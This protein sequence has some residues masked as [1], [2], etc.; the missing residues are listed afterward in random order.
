MG[1]GPASREGIGRQ[2]GTD[3]LHHEPDRG[4]RPRDSGRVSRTHL[5][6]GRRTIERVLQRNGLTAPRVHLAP[7]LPPQEYPGP[8]ARASNQLHEV[9]LVGPIYLKGQSHPAGTQPAGSRRRGQHQGPGRA[10]RARV[11]GMSRYHSGDAYVTMADGSARVPKASIA[12]PVSD[13]PH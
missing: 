1:T 6:P 8:Q 9:D 5:L 12:V 2:D 10:R 7:L 4:P 11:H 3:D 13:R